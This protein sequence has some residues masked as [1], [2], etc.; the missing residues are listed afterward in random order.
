[1]SQDAVS[2]ITQLSGILAIATDAIISLD[3]EYRITLF[4]EGAEQIFGYTQDEML[5]Q[6]LDRLLPERVRAAHRQHIAVFAAAPVASRRMAERSKIAGC[7]K[8]GEEFPAEASIARLEIEGRLVFTVILRDITDRLRQEQA[9]EH[10]EERLRLALQT[11]HIGL[12]E[13]DHRDGSCYWSPT[14][15]HILGVTETEPASLE[16]YAERV[17]ADE[18]PSV[19]AAAEKSYDPAGDGTLVL[20][21]RLV[22]LDRPVQWVSL[23]SQTYF[24][25]TGSSRTP[26]RT[27]GVLRDIT[28]RKLSE[29]ILADANRELETR[30]A[31]RTRALE[32]ELIRRDQM[33][34]A[35]V[36]AQRLEAVG[37]LT[38]GVA[39]DFNNLLTVITGNQE[40]LEPHV[41][42]PKARTLLRRAQDAT[43]MAARLTSRLLI[44]ARQRRFE[45][46][47]LNLN[48]QIQAMA[49]LLARTLGETIV[50]KTNLAA[51][52][53]PVRADAS[54]VENAVLNLAINAR[55]A[56]KDGG[57]L[58]I[59]SENTRIEPEAARVE[60]GM[61]PGEFVR[62]SV[63]DT[64][65]GMPPAVLARAFE[66]FF[67]TKATGQ[68]TGLGLSTIYGFARQSGGFAQIYS[69][70]G[71]GT[72]VNIYLPRAEAEQQAAPAALG[73]D[74]QFSERGE[75]IL[76]VEDNDDVREA[77]LQ[78]TEG[79]G[80]AVLEA[81]NGAAA[82]A[83]LDKGT[84]VDLVFSDVV[85]AGGVSGFDLVRWLTK[86]RPQIKVLLTS[87]FS[88]EA[89]A[90]KASRSQGDSQPQLLRKP[91]SRA[92]LSQALRQALG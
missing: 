86:H 89:L 57:K 87:G 21:H 55:D 49:D 75:T 40:L 30:V 45:P 73:H 56:I 19:V 64:G 18:W 65:S 37:Q 22:Q 90:E 20:A 72:T 25:G 43:D 92:Q 76:V 79:L 71:E 54:E 1:M 46:M 4:G 68:G 62:L 80:Y 51:D 82:I 59:Q 44:F 91:Y 41:T 81:G 27:I 34:A 14:F 6:P 85:M 50:L 52:L 67:T 39:H 53:W 26:S 88:A 61:V 69:E 74:V 3:Q 38:G 60:V 12:S 28:E 66:P 8:S 78:R 17:P 83:L 15:R 29:Q 24:T 16:T 84:P 35:L 10:S 5:G 70:V 47:L 13:Y 9:L 33:Q 2:A 31:E 63:T 42:H 23:V 11:G 36:K 48:D 7:R 58:I 32:E 77:T